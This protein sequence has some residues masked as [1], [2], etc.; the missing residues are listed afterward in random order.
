MHTLESGVNRSKSEAYS[1]S[2]TPM[3]DKP[4]LPALQRIEFAWQFLTT[5]GRKV[6]S[7]QL[8]QQQWQTQRLSAA[9]SAMTE[10]HLT[11]WSAYPQLLSTVPCCCMPSTSLTANSQCLHAIPA[12]HEN[13]VG[14]LSFMQLA[15]VKG[16]S[17]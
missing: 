10:Q 14:S 3:A 7:V 13:L 2:A 11:D 8:Q 15:I 4:P 9:S 6:L 16:L 17:R 1:E 5:R 12:G